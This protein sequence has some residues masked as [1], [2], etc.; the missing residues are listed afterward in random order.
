MIPWDK[1]A[2]G[3]ANI[4]VNGMMKYI[5]MSARMNDLNGGLFQEYLRDYFHDQCFFEPEM[6]SGN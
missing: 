2:A 3:A 4:L 1:D 6:N 5:T